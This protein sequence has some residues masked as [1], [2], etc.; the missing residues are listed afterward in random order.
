MDKRSSIRGLL[1]WLVICLAA[2]TAGA[3]LTGPGIRS[4]WY[5]SLAKPSWTPPSWVFGP[6][7]T[8]LYAAMGVAAWMVWQREEGLR[9]HGR[10]WLFG[11]QLAAN[12]IWS[13]L[14][15]TFHD[16]GAAM[17][18]LVVLWILV[19]STAVA[20]WRIHRPAGLLLVPY[21]AWLTYAATLNFS[22]WRLNG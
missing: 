6:V 13:A 9:R 11:A 22:I 5:A 17:A 4:G 10:L 1:V 2:E 7:W 19:V 3:F 21:L 20:F 12:V 14:F 15:F 8:L 18:D 16:P